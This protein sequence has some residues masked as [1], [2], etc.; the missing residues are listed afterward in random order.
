MRLAL[1]RTARR[2][3]GGRLLVAGSPLTVFRLGPAGAGAVDAIVAGADVG[4]AA[5]PRVDRLH[6]TGAAHPPPVGPR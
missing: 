1:D 6:D 2:L 5:Q 4:P 3:D